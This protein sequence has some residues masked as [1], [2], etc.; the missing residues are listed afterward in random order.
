MGRTKR[1]LVDVLERAAPPEDGRRRPAEK[2]EGRLR[3]AGV[4]ER[5]DRV[6][7]ARSGRDGRHA[8][9]AREPGDGVGRE[10]G[11]R[12]VPRVDDA[13]AARLR[14]GEDRRDVPAAEREQEPHARAGRG[15]R[16]RGRPRT[17]QT[18]SASRNSGGPLHL[19]S[20]G[21]V[22]SGCR[23]R[24]PSGRSGQGAPGAPRGEPGEGE[25]GREEGRAERRDGEGRLHRRRRLEELHD[26]PDRPASG[27][28]RRPRGGG[29]RACR[30]RSPSR[31]TRSNVSSGVKTFFSRGRIEIDA[32]PAGRVAD[33]AAEAERRVDDGLP[34]PAAALVDLHEARSRRRGR[35]SRTSRSRRTSRGR[36]P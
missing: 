10:D 28:S 14:R 31:R 34:A 21:E 25:R 1:E 3:E 9:H 4:L 32:E 2:D 11:G 22:S 35:P 18:P 8:R 36:P 20:C 30:A 29:R 5:R 24:L 16:R 27:G 17:S 15:P 33:A 23:M 7:H 6:R 12:L 26:P 13:D 19:I